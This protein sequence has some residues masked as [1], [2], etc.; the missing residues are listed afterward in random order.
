MLRRCS[1]GLLVLG[2]LAGADDVLAAQKLAQ[3]LR[4]PVV[5]DVLSGEF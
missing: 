5:C 1:R 3:Q 4:W 2:E